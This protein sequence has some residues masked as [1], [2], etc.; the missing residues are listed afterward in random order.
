MASYE[1]TIPGKGKFVVDS[2]T[3][4]S[5][6]QVYQAALA[7]VTGPNPTEGMST[8]Q[9]V[10]A[11]VGKTF[12]D[13]ARGAGQVARDV[14]TPSAQILIDKAKGA[15]QPTLADTAG[16][17]T[18]KDVADARAL[19]QPLMQTGAGQAG[20]FAGGVAAAA[21]TILAPGAN[22]AV[23]AGLAGGLLGLLQP[24]V[25]GESRQLNTNLGA[26]GG[27]L[28]QGAGNW[29]ANKVGARLANQT[30][31]ATNQQATNAVRD[32]TLTE[33]RQAGYVFP[34]TQVNPSVTN[35]VMEAVSGKIKTAQ[36]AA[37]KNQEVTNNLAKRALGIAPD[38]PLTKAT[39]GDVREQAGQAYAS[40]EALPSINWDQ[41]FER[42]VKALIPAGTGAVKNPAKGEISELAE[43]L[44]KK[45]AWTGGELVEDIKLLR[46]MGHANVSAASRAG[47]DTA[48]S[49]LG[50]AQLKASALLEDLAERNLANNKAPANTIQELKNARQLIAKTYDV[51]KALNDATGNVNASV[52]AGLLKKGK[53]LTGDLATVGRTASA[54]PKATQSADQIGSVNP[55][56]A[57]DAMF[58][59]GAAVGTGNAAAALA[60]LARPGIRSLVL[61]GPYQNNMLQPN[62][63]AG[64]LTRGADKLLWNPLVNRSTGLLGSVGV[65][66]YGGQ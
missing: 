54:F 39:L 65:L 11:G 22:T 10:L 47:G 51:E 44:L 49:M 25:E 43:S 9:K 52:V 50:K 19:D 1:V 21:P 38:A 24:T 23:G 46:E 18:T 42:S 59:T 64:L 53:P 35:T 6:Q 5:D 14:L 40:V 27:M 32:A 58:S 48:K 7:N 28:A 57:V 16:L 26:A 17:P 34:P 30:N 20:A 31:Q 33:A 12:T 56:S 4:L 66:G 60:P 2:P 45:A 41:S 13:L 15:P 55:L 3:E 62:Y 63:N 29:L 36:S 37:F 61:S 8:G